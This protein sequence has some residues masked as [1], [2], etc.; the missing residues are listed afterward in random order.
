MLLPI[1]YKSNVKTS[2]ADHDIESLFPIIYG[3]DST[4]RKYNNL[5][6]YAFNVYQG[7][8]PGIATTI[9]V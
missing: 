5:F 3:F 1:R 6:G 4:D 7:D 9:Q 2:G 8:Q